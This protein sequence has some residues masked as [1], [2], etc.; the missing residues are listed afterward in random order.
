MTSDMETRELL[1]QALDVAQETARAA[2]V[3]LL[4]HQS[5]ASVVR[6]KTSRDALLDAD[7]AAESIILEH[8]RT[9][10]PQHVVLS[11]EAGT[12]SGDDKHY[13]WV[14]DPLDGSANYLRGSPLFGVAI[15]LLT[16]GVASV[17]AIYLPALGELYCAV[18]GGGAKC[19]DVAIHCAE[20]PRLAQA[21]IHVGDFAKS[22]RHRDNI[23]RL[24]GVEP[25]AD[26]AG[27]VRMV[28]S[29]A[30]D[31]AFVACGRADGLVMFGSTPWDIEAGQLL[32][33][34]AGC[35]AAERGIRRQF[36]YFCSTLS[37]HA[38]LLRTVT[39]AQLRPNT[40]RRAPTA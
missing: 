4:E 2:G 22:G 33:M 30:A 8:I 37:I 7:L 15:A 31:F 35:V 26:K 19:N 32:A 27:R 3:Y 29:A 34:E 38:E 1:A 21:V 40:H 11:E 17:G 16:D 6:Q 36:T 28:G 24:A 14:V 9:A 18:R 25:L 23:Y 12:S 5:T 39:R 20:T 13:K 10:F